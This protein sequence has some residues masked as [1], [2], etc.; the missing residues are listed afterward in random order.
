MNKAEFTETLDRER[1]TGDSYAAAPFARISGP[2]SIR[3]RL[4]HR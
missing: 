4:S 3:K 1:K 2:G